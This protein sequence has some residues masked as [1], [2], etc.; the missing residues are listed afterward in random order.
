MKKMQIEKDW[1]TKSGLRSF[2]IYIEDSKHR[3][4][5]VVV[6]EDNIF[7]GANYSEIEE[8]FNV[9][10]GITFSGPLTFSDNEY[11]L[12]YD[13][14]HGYDFSRFNPKGKVRDLEYCV[15]ECESLAAQLQVQD[16]SFALLFRAKKTNNNNKLPDNLHNKMI[17]L[18]V[19]GDKNAKEYLELIKN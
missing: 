1:I 14:A 8:N 6:P 10:G 2:V 12:G 9:H 3:C 5:Y 19:D 16:S 4:G 15:E 18:A 11:A 17:M 7:H 13:T